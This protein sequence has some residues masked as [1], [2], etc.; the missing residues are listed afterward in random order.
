MRGILRTDEGRD[1]VTRTG[2]MGGAGGIGSGGSSATSLLGFSAIGSGVGGGRSGEGAREIMASDPL[3]MLPR[4]V[5]FIRCFTCRPIS[6]AG[7]PI[8]LLMVI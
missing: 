7:K 6:V 2:G 5:G 8:A 3:D 1:A 4:V